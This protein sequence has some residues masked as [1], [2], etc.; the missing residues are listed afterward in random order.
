MVVI[1]QM[2]NGTSDAMNS[3]EAKVGWSFGSGTANSTAIRTV[4][5]KRS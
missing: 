5:F 4:F 1:T 2:R 3:F